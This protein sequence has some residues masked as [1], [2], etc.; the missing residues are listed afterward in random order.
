MAATL[1]LIK[2]F[3]MLPHAGGRGAGRGRGTQ[4]RPGRAAA[5]VP[6]LS[7]GRR[8]AR[9]ARALGPRRLRRA[10]REAA[11]PPPEEEAPAPRLNVSLFDLVEAMAAV[12]KRLTDTTPRE[13]ALRDIPVAECIPRI[14]AAL[15]QRVT[16]WNSRRCSRI[17]AIQRSS[18]GDR[19]LHGAAGADSAGQGACAP[20]AIATGRSCS[21]RRD[22]M[23]HA[24]RRRNAGD[25][26]RRRAAAVRR[27]IIK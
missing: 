3:S 12:L 27:G 13:I 5:R 26:P 8:E 20:G 9:R 10:G 24:G 18:G 21:R 17:F 19:D 2:S 4:A 1:L 25:A 11:E 23:R 22:R 15:E 7:R 16:R 14:M 6:A